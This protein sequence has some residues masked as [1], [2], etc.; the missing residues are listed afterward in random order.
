MRF[1]AAL[2]SAV[3]LALLAPVPSAQ[4]R[5]TTPKEHLGFDLGDDYTLANYQQVADY[6]RKLDGESDRMVLQEI[7]KTAE[8][9]PHLMAVVTSP[10]NHRNLPR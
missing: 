4:T 1:R 7:G 5:I 3:L 9:R 10:E 6:W 2:C 8:G